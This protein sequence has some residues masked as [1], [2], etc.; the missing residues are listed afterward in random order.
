MLKECSFSCKSEVVSFLTWPQKRRA[1]RQGA[2]RDIVQAFFPWLERCAGYWL[3]LTW[4]TVSFWHGLILKEPG[5]LVF[6]ERTTSS[7]FYANSCFCTAYLLIPMSNFHVASPSR[8]NKTPGELWPWRFL[9]G[10]ITF[11]FATC[12]LKSC[13]L[14][15]D[16]HFNATTFPCFHEQRP[17]TLPTTPGIFVVCK[18]HCNC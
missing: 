12:N 3:A 15:L 9:R 4:E 17:L 13:S 8:Q 16:V 14:F 10:V 1:S 5:W 2:C 11:A 18:P 7:P 6:Q